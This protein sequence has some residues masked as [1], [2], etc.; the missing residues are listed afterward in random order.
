MDTLE[1]MVSGGKATAGPP[2]G[3]QLGPL[4]V[5]IQA[6]IA[7]INKQTA[8]MAGMQVPVKL[9]VDKVTKEFNVEIGTPPISSLIL[10]E[11]K[12]AK[13]TGKARYEKVGNISKDALQRIANIKEA[14]LG[15]TEL[16]RLKQAIGTCVSAGVTVDGHDPRVAMGIVTG[17]LKTA[18]QIEAAEKEV[19]AATNERASEKAAKAAAKAAAEAAVAQGAAPAEGAAAPAAEEKK[20]EEK[21]EE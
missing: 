17:E 21:A 9:H 11:A 18:E 15:G 3:P 10:K 16:S 8:P 7:E 6:I 5:N 12:A 14:T 2:I 20:K 19:E 1:F 4:G 13:G